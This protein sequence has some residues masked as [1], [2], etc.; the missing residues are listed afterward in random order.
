MSFEIMHNLVDQLVG[1]GEL[2]R[3]IATVLT[4]SHKHLHGK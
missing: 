3:G 2:V 1:E 4:G